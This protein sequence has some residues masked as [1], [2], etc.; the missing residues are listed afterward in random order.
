[1]QIAKTALY[2]DSAVG[3]R[4]QWKQ[5]T[6]FALK[7][8]AALVEFQHRETAS[9]AYDLTRIS[10]DALSHELHAVAFHLGTI[11]VVAVKRQQPVGR[12]FI[13]KATSH[14]VADTIQNLGV[15]AR[16]MEGIGGLKHSH[17]NG[18]LHDALGLLRQGTDRQAE[19]KQNG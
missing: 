13:T 5:L 7:M 11:D 1:M 3:V 15:E 12:G 4:T 14:I 9:T 6:H 18:V 10:G 19:T 8:E 2:E 16:D 17:R